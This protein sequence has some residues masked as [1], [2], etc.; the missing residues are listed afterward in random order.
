MNT[1]EMVVLKHVV[2]D[3]YHDKQ[4]EAENKIV[5]SFHSKSKKNQMNREQYA[6]K[7]HSVKLGREGAVWEVGRMQGNKQEKLLGGIDKKE[8]HCFCVSDDAFS[9]LS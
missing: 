3:K 2:K 7:Q 5:W 9:F 1:F 8:F 4:T 6:Y